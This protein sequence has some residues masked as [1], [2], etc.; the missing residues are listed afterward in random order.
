[1]NFINQSAFLKAL[2]W[3]L[4]D[5]L[6]Q[7]G[8]MWLVYMCLTANGKKFQAR[9]RHTIALLSLTGGTLWFVVTL[10]VNFYKAAAAPEIVTVYLSAGEQFSAQPLM[11]RIAGFFE[12]ALPYLS[13]AYLAVACFLFLR[14]Y[15]HYYRTRQLYTTGIQKAHPEWRVFLQQAVQHMGIKKKITIWFSSLVD[16]PLTLGFWKPVI[17]LPVAAVNHLSIQQAE[18]IILHELNHIRRN[19]YLVNLLIA[20]TDIILFFNPFTRFLTGIVRKEREHSC[21]DLVLQ[22]R[23]DPT[24]YAKALLTLEQNRCGATSSLALAATGKNQQF[25]L[26]RVKRI[27][28]KENTS[29][30]VPQ[31]M[32]AFLLSALLIGFIGLYNPGKIITRT[33]DDV[34]TP[35]ANTEAPLSF[36][37]PP[38]ADATENE[39]TPA[40]DNSNEQEEKERPANE[41]EVE[42]TETTKIED[43]IEL[44]A[45]VKLAA[46]TDK[47]EEIP[48]MASF[49]NA[50]QT[51]DFAFQEAASA[52]A[53]AEAK[54]EVYPFVPSSSFSYQVMEDTT[55]P[56]KYIM[57]Y[58]EKKTKE[59]VEK[60]MLALQ[61]VD[62]KKL[63]KE[64]NSGSGKIDIVKLQQEIEKAVK[65]VDWKKLDEETQA[66][67]LSEEDLA[68][69][70]EAYR[71]QLGN[72]QQERARK[73]E[74]IKNAQQQ[75]LLD[76][77]AQH[78]KLKHTEATKAAK[79]DCSSSASKAKSTAPKATTTVKKKKIV[80][81]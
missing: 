35:L 25:L 57:T 62:W 10:I 17:L 74:Q 31:R 38:V 29:A 33:I 34:R 36:Q 15:R 50:W 75:V 11:A 45:D 73:Q 32:I 56:K 20:C 47:L 65:E 48:Q 60:A 78:E 71:V 6:W 52:A 79:S 77:L 44:A 23:Y 46:I 68:K 12:P 21:D 26:N 55:L 22:F 63:E 66:A 2:G 53:P 7:M 61:F 16:T 5:S 1:M 9:Q 59:A 54:S 14:F 80:H 24:A 40:P 51:I 76:R 67:L 37:T 27:L 28:A 13:I 19:D 30:P 4:L 81:I 70:Q 49:A 3:S 42:I 58:T 41:D 72:Y 18:A 64:I 69:Y 8:L 39:A 43:L